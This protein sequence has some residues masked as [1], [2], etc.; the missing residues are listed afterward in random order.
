MLL[1]ERR[2]LAFSDDVDQTIDAFSTCV[3][4]LVDI[5]II[6]SIGEIVVQFR[7]Q[8]CDSSAAAAAALNLTE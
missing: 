4:I 8:P 6:V 7:P 1:S 3:F 5:Y 2:L